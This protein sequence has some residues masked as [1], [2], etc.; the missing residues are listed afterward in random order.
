[1][2]YFDVGATGEK[3]K[4]VQEALLALG[5]ELPKYGADGVVN[6]E[7]IAA[8]EDF[9]EDHGCSDIVNDAWEWWMD[10]VVAQG[11]VSSVMAMA[12]DVSRS[13]ISFQSSDVDFH[14]I[15]EVHPRKASKGF[16]PW[17]QITGITLHQTGIML[18]NNF[19][20]FASLRAHIGILKLK[21]PTIV[22]VYPFNVLLHHGNAFNSTDVGIEINGCFEG[23]D[24]K[25]WTAWKGGYKNEPHRCTDEQ[26]IAARV[27]VRKICTD[28]EAH[29]GEVRFIH[30]HRQTSKTRQSDPGSRVWKEVGVWA[31]KVLGLG[32]GGDGFTLRDGLPIP[33]QWDPNRT[34]E[35]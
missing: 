32:D 17:K 8:L 10:V 14:D 26:I 2:G 13:D 7:T 11:V 6:F 31:Q 15:S 9:S 18:G 28:V 35:Y 3:I 24:G 19:S 27:A 20:R 25:K 30:A 12:K 22:Q 23:I 4:E 33:R 16:R 34:G 1:M 21:R 29:G 5:Y